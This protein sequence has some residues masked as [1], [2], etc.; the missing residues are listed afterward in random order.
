MANVLYVS[1]S[2]FD[3]NASNASEY[4]RSLSES[5]LKLGLYDAFYFNLMNFISMKYNRTIYGKVD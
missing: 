5:S 1:W 4:Q 2:A 3:L